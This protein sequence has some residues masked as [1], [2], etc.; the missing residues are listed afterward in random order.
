M[1][2]ALATLGYAAAF[3][4]PGEVAVAGR[5]VA[6]LGGAFEGP[7]L[8][9]QGSLLVTADLAEMAA[10]LGQPPLPLATLAEFGPVPAADAIGAALAAAFAAALGVEAAAA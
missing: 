7:S 6:G 9:H 1:A 5:K 3:R 2:A 4:A 8:M 10:L